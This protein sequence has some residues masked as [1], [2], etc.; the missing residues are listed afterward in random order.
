MACSRPLVDAAVCA[1]GALA[2]GLLLIAPSPAYA[3]PGAYAEC[4]VLD[5]GLTG[6]PTSDINVIEGVKR[7]TMTHYGIGRMDAVALA[8]KQMVA[9]CPIHQQQWSYAEQRA[10]DHGVRS[11]YGPDN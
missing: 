6:D 4:S 5:S 7:S 3:D 1:L 8:W 9:Y 10:L 2:C 11:Y